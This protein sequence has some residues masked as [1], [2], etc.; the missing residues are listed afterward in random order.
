MEQGLLVSGC[1]PQLVRMRLIDVVYWSASWK[2]LL[3]S[4]KHQLV[5]LYILGSWKDQSLYFEQF[6]NAEA[7]HAYLDIR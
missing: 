3:D 1:L 7:M 2:T 5:Q 4:S 6:L